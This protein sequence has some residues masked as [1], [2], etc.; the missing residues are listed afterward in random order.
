MTGTTAGGIDRS[1]PNGIESHTSVT[2]LDGT[3]DHDVAICGFSIKFPGDATSPEAF[4]RMIME[5]RCAMTEFPSNR[6]NIPPRGGNFIK[7]DPSVFDANFFSISPAEAT[8][9]D[10]MQRWLLETAF[11]ALENAGITMESISGSSTSVYTGSFGLDY[12]T[13]LNRDPESP[14]T[15]AGLGFGISMLANRLSWFFNLQGPSIGLDSACSSS[16][17][18]VDIACQ[19]L[20]NGSCDMSMVAGCNLTFAPETYNWLTNIGFLSPDSRCYSFDHRANGYARGEG[21]A[22][23]ILKRLKDAILDGNTIRA[24]IRATGSNE[25]GRTPGITQPTTAAQERLIR[26]TY[27]RA[28][29]SMAHTRYFEAHGTGTAIG[30]PREAQAIGQAFQQ[31]RSILDPIYVG[32]VKS[33]IGHLEGASGLAGLIKAVLVLE[34]GVIPPN[35][36]FEKLNPKIDAEY[37]R[38]KFPEQSYLW[39]TLGLR[40][41]SVNS[42]GYGGANS[43]IVLDDAYNYMRLRSLTGKHCTSPSIPSIISSADHKDNSRNFKHDINFNDEKSI[44]LYV[45]SAA[46]KDGIFRIAQAYK[47]HY[48]DNLPKTAKQTEFLSD[49]AFTLDSH[50]SH[51]SWRS[52]ALLQSPGELCHLQPLISPP[53]RAHAKPPRLGFV[54]S[55]QGSQWFAMGRELMCYASFKAE[56][57]RAERFLKGTGCRWSVIDELMMLKETSNVDKAEFSQ[58]LCTVLQVALAN[59]LKRFGVNPTAV[60]GHSSGEIAAAYAAGYLTAESAWKVAYFR[61]LLAAELSESPGPQPSGAMMSVGLS[62]DRAMDL[63][64]TVEQDT[65]AFG[66]SVA[67]INSPNNVTISGEVHLIDKLKRRLDEKGVFARKLRVT[68]AYHSRQMEAISGRYISMMG[69]LSGTKEAKV[70]MISTVTGE[71]IPKSR[72]IDPSYW[73]LNMTSPVQFVQA[74]TRMCAQ[75]DANLVKKIDKS[76][77]SAFVVDHLVEIGPHATL[78]GPLQDILR[79]V[80]RGPSIGYSTILRREIPATETLLRA[81]GELHCMGLRLNLREINE[82]SQDPKLFRSMLTDL[83]EYPFDHPQMYWHESR[84]SKNYRF[85]DHAPSEFLG[86]RSNDWNPSEARWRHFIRTSEMPWVEQHVVNGTVLYSGSGMLVMAIEGA[87]QVCGQD[88]PISGFVLRDVHIEG[89]MDLTANGGSLEVQTSLREL[90]PRSQSGTEFEFTIQTWSN[91][92]WLLNCR[93]FVSVE[94]PE[95]DNWKRKG[96]SSQRQDVAKSLETIISNCDTPIDAQRMYSFL[97]GCGLEYGS[98]FQGAQRQHHDG[99]KEAASN[100]RLFKPHNNDLEALQ[101]HVIHPASLDTVIHLCFTALTSGGTRPMAT[102]VISR[103]GCLWISCEGLSW[104]GTE[105]VTACTSITSSSK[106]GFSCYGGALT[107]SKER[108]VKIWYDNLELAYVSSL[109]T[110]PP[111]PNPRQFCMYVDSKPSLVKLDPDEICALLKQQHPTEE[112][113][114]QVFEDIESLVLVSLDRL[115]N[116]IDLKTLDDQEPWKQHYWRWAE[117]CLHHKRRANPRSEQDLLVRKLSRS[118]EEVCSRLKGMNNIGRIFSQVALNLTAIFNREVNPQGLLIETGVLESYYEELANCKCADRASSYVDLLAHQTPGLNILEIGGGS[119]AFTRKLIGVLRAQPDETSGSLRCHQYDFTDCSPVS[120]QKAQAEFQSNTSQMNFG[121]L[122]ITQDIAVQ[123]YKEGHYDIVIASNVLPFASDVSTSLHNIRMALKPG[124]RLLIQEPLEPSAWTSGFVFG[125]FPEWWGRSTVEDDLPLSPSMTVESW[126]VVLEKNG[127]SCIDMTINDSEPNVAHHCGWL[128]STVADKK[129]GLRQHSGEGHHTTIIV[130]KSSPHQQSLAL[131]LISPLRDLLGVGPDILSI[132]EAISTPERNADEL[133]ILLLDY[134]MSF[135]KSLTETTWKQLKT[136]IQSSHHLLWVSS[137]GGAAADPSHGI[138]DGLTRTLRLEFYDL[139]LVTLALDIA[140]HANSKVLPLMNIVH[141]MITNAPGQN[142]EQEYVEMDGVLHTRRLVEAS[143]LKSTMDSKLEPYEISS[144][145]ISS[146]VPFKVSTPST[147]NE[148]TPH[149]IPFEVQAEIG[150]DIVEVKVVAASL[151]P[152]DRAII[153]D[154]AENQR[155]GNYCT[156]IVIRAGSKATF[157]P[158]DRVFAACD[159]SLHSHICVRSHAVT[160]LPS[161]LSF[162]HSCWTI[163]PLVVAYNALVDV[164]RVQPTESVLVHDTA[165]PIGQAALFILHERGVSNVWASA[166]DE[167]ESTW[168]T[169]AF[170][171]PQ[172]RIF[173]KDWFSSQAMLVSQLK[174][175]FDVVLSVEADSGLPLLM[176]H[177]KSGG[178]YIMLRDTSTSSNSQQVFCV[179]PSIS[180]FI[181]GLDETRFGSHTATKETLQ[182]AARISQA[183]TWDTGKYRTVEF[184]A[185]Q[186]E[187]AFD[188]LRSA[189]SRETVVIKFDDADI[190]D[191]RIPRRHEDL[192]DSNAT[193]VI[194]GGLGGL[195]RGI[196]RWF[197][198]RGARHLVLLSRS[199]PRTPEALELVA[200]LGRKG[201]CVEAPPCDVT[202]RSILGSVLADCAKKMP[203]IRGCVQAAMVMKEFIFQKLEYDDWKAAVDPKVEASWNLHAELPRGLDFFI[204][205]SSIQGILGSASLAGYNAGNTYLDALARYRVAQGERAISLDLGGVLDSGYLAEHEA[206]S[207]RLQ[208]KRL[209]L[210]NVKEIDA[211]LDIYCDPRATHSRSSVRCQPIVGIRPPSHWKDVEEIPFTLE[212]PFWGHMHHLPAPSSLDGEEN[213]DDVDGTRKVSLNVAE[214]LAAAGSLAEAAEIVSQGLEERVS[215]LL[216]TSKEHLSEKKPMYSYGVD[217]L[218]AIELRNW[219]GQTFNVDL[220]VFE[221]L[222]GATFASAGMSIAR[223]A[224]LKH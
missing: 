14:P 85:R 209:A 17:M 219:V 15:Y 124:G 154:L 164:A 42:F 98:H 207:S 77:L 123:G 223:K 165:N 66:V 115:I 132:E 37:L 69:S 163:P 222:G 117:Y 161:D 4:W 10:P 138:I 95:T 102:C 23:L 50:R 118:F 152:S 49:L 55:G 206:A 75:S 196:S 145:P 3:N 151:L 133:V 87:R 113:T 193:Y 183:A 158:G 70:P 71:R 150:D 19:A 182:Y 210:M 180:L 122:D 131:A 104:P 212:Q 159:G 29:L 16:A 61:G 27:Q 65:P 216:G 136:L 176:S 156:G 120:V 76:H 149:Y 40:R 205:I 215:S 184:L 1:L 177:V 153:N 190:V 82:P 127:F 47:K 88:K 30:D 116:S 140:D 31:H 135:V 134:G 143:N 197:V 166:V 96:I 112:D 192:L 25:N 94:Y 202:N 5:K 173:P 191:V 146:Q 195:G 86:V 38:L 84:L 101:S 92:N 32:A 45:W 188:H 211:L 220:P 91:D 26:E 167:D 60:V 218:S 148:N 36:N 178:R 59:L 48:I 125:L 126:N 64:A 73:A 157:S 12:T 114:S 58:T 93:G 103:I 21:I 170:G 111:I 203:P 224:Q 89:P 199:G 20:R 28:G 221:I 11:R 217:S 186:I 169:E 171:I 109:P 79:L 62:E 162:T 43:H 97:K 100:V 57:M 56:L 107:D 160:K 68:L 53:A 8:G 119:G 6:F 194:S 121:T 9:M 72:L 185:S 90:R 174:Q 39:P 81:M 201:A 175:M 200:E 18:G 83:P 137:G 130:D 24:V 181:I 67:C 99:I 155:F 54:F 63:A 187:D 35:T 78:R 198:S 105:S 52:F 33:N 144:L 147:S 172:E 106:R 108:D 46:D 213:P 214:R 51:L 128:V 34:K 2:E 168:I 189:S 41:A 141:E 80:P 7:E 110:P 139:H 44:R 22:V 208:T 204:L 142:Y 13:Q 129:G 74:V 179:P